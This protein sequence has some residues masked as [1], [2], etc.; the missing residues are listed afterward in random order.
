ARHLDGTV[1]RATCLRHLRHLLLRRYG[2]CPPPALGR[3]G[4]QHTVGPA[5]E[6]RPAG[7]R[8]RRRRRVTGGPAPGRDG[9]RVARGL[10]VVGAKP[11]T[12]SVWNPPGPQRWVR[13]TVRR[14]CNKAGKR[15]L[16]RVDR[17]ARGLQPTTS[18][19][20]AWGRKR[21]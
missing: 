17:E 13:G 9:A 8:A 15:R 1:V 6:T 12:C 11:Y 20:A 2:S 10:R 5:D 19:R 3:P 16:Q 7:G 4:L 21:E 14:E 18:A